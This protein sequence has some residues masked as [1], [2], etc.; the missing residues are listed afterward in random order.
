MTGQVVAWLRRCLPGQAIHLVGDGAYAVIES[1][2]ICQRQQVTLIAPLRLDS[3]L[4]EQAYRPLVKGRGRPAVVGAR[5]PNLAQ[6]ALA[7][8]DPVATESTALVG[9]NDRHS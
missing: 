7:P 4:F 6:I 1:G 8:H 9:R 5:L 2:L 3:R